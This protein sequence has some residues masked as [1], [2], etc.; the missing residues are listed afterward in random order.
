M[1]PPIRMHPVHSWARARCVLQVLLLMERVGEAQRHAAMEM[2]S[3]EGKK[4]GRNGKRAAPD[5]EA[6]ESGLQRMMQ[7]AARGKKPRH[8]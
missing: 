6:D 7:Q 1:H 2:R 3:T 8:S 5:D 4:K